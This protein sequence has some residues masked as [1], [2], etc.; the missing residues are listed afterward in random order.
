MEL[1]IQ[2]D[3]DILGYEQEIAVCLERMKAQIDSW[4]LSYLLTSPIDGHVSFVRKWD[5]GQ[6]IG[7][8]ESFLTVVPAD[9]S[10]A[11]GIVNIP[12]ASFGK[13]AVGQKVNVCLNGYPYME[14]GMLVGEIG[15]LSSVPD[16][17]SGSQAEPQYTAEIVFPDGFI[18]T[19]G[20]ELRL[21][22]KMDGTAEIIT[23]D[24][25]LIMRFIEP[26]VALFRNGI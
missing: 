15:Y 25:R 5:E 2:E 22:Q 9:S 23:E 3:D 24:R 26:I 18:T 19:Y 6:F 11:V 12:Q 8:G 16:E 7:A 1:S 14:Y 4:K 13:V 17:A 10:M 20:K 21:I